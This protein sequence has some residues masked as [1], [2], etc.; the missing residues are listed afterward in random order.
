MRR[1]KEWWACLTEE[2]RSRLVFLERSEKLSGGYGG[3]GY[4]PDD[5]CECGAC[6]TPHLGMGL[7]P[8]C[9]REL[10]EIIELADKVMEARGGEMKK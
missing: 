2:Q 4:L 10:C 1:T 7:C 6:S 9:I 5:C 3:G 8:Y